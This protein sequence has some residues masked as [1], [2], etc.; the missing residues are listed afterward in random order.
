MLNLDNIHRSDV[1]DFLFQEAALLDAWQ[2]DDW[3]ELLT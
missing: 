1:E 3:L 2:L